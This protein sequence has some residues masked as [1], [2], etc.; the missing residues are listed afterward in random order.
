MRYLLI[1]LVCTFLIFSVCAGAD[2]A[3]QAMIADICK[4]SDSRLS[5]D[6]KGVVTDRQTGL[7]W[8]PGNDKDTSWQEAR[9]WVDSLVMDGVGWRLPSPVELQAL[10]DACGVENGVPNIFGFVGSWVWAEVSASEESKN[11]QE[12]GNRH[13]AVA[14]DSGRIL[15]LEAMA[16]FNLRVLAV[17]GERRQQAETVY[18]KAV[19][20]LASD[21]IYISTRSPAISISLDKDFILVKDVAEGKQSLFN[22]KGEVA[23]VLIR[24]SADLSESA[25]TEQLPDLGVESWIA[26]L[27]RERIL[28]AGALGAAGEMWFYVDRVVTGDTNRRAVFTRDLRLYVED[29]HFLNIVFLEGLDRIDGRSW[30]DCRPLTVRQRQYLEKVIDGFAKKV[31]IRKYRD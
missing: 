10:Y 4:G 3:S 22:R 21:R 26:Q 27:H 8:F 1:R 7:Q 16:S 31:E 30:S 15:D 19:R 24:H 18:R 14:F 2:S 23:Y 6:A 25:Q 12:N 5:M 20:G 9:N 17:R 13:R 29:L 28:G 11:R